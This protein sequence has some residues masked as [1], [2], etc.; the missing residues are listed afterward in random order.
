MTTVVVGGAGEVGGLLA[1]LLLPDGPVVCADVRAAEI[2]GT[3][4]IVADACR[5]SAD[6]LGVVRQA[7][8][9]VFALPEHVAVPAV[10][11]CAPAVRPGA[12]LVETLSVKE[13]VTPALAGAAA[14][15]D[16][17]ACGLNPMFAPALGWQDNAVAAVRVAD[18][19]R[20]TALLGSITAAG[21]RVVELTAGEHDRVTAVLQAATHA[22]ALAFG[23]AVVAGGAD[24]E[25]L[26]AL[27]PPPHLTMLAVLARITG[28]NPEVY[29]DIQVANPHAAAARAALREAVATIDTLASTGDRAGFNALLHGVEKHLGDRAPLLRGYCARLF[30]MRLSARS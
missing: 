17:E 24:A 11:A 27:A 25:A 30:T 26:L 15:R 6:L 19:P 8:T 5:P 21:A 29:W 13:A 1:R 23:Q 4:A 16:A 20:T 12:L 22:A 18:G 28:G 3:V 9:V 14:S 2:P 7:G 10:T